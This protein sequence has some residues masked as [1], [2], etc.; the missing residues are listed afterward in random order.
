MTRWGSYLAVALVLV[1]ALSIPATAKDAVTFGSTT[2]EKQNPN[3]KTIDVPLY[4]SNAKKLGAIDVPLTF[5]QPGDGVNLIEVDFDESRAH[6]FDV[7]VAN[8]DNDNKTVLIGLLW[9]AYNGDQVELD[10]GQGP[11]ATLRF[12]VTDPMLESFVIDQ[13]TFEHPHHRLGF[14]YDEIGPDGKL[15]VYWGDVDFEPMTIDVSSMKVNQ[16][17]ESY[18]L[19]QN[20]PNPFNASTVIKF[21][22]PNDAHVTLDVFNILGQRV[23]TLKNEF[24]SAGQHQ[25]TWNSDEASGVYFYRLTTD[26]F[27]ETRKMTLLK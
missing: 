22:L 9:M 27:S 15:N 26:E 4:F 7:K 23:T 18:E 14:V 10:P 8:I 2:F 17:P 25:V 16:V 20:Y 5:G 6:Y 11:L 19:S 1:L 12:E 3:T 21:G 24:M 13:T